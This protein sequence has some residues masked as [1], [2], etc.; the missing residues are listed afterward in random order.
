M[1]VAELFQRTLS[2]DST[3]RSYLIRGASDEE[4]A[5]DEMLTEAPASVGAMVRVDGKCTVEETDETGTYS[6]RCFY[7]KS[8]QAV[9]NPAGGSDLDVGDT[10]ILFNIGAETTHITQSLANVSKTAASGTATDHKGAIGV[11]LDLEA[12][13]TDILSLAVD[14]EIIKIV[15][16]SDLTSAYLSTVIGIRMNPMNASAFTH[17]DSDGREVS[18]AAGEGLFLGMSNTPRGNGEDELRFAFAASQTLENFD[19]GDI[20]VPLKAGWNHVWVQYGHTEDSSSG[21]MATRPVAAYVERVYGT[22]NF[23][24]LLL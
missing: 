16:S 12:R 5:R 20:T 7:G 15:E 22:S 19:V 10:R 14:F 23:G 11:D 17:Q 13:G 18:L 6:G 8:G 24:G 1:S 4:S 21:G 9:G 2:G 3:E